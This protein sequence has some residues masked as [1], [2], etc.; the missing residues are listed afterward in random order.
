MLH[1][2]SAFCVRFQVYTCDAAT[3]EDCFRDM[4]ETTC[5]N[6]KAIS[7]HV[8]VLSTKEP[9]VSFQAQSLGDYFQDHIEVDYPKGH[10]A[11]LVF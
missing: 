4:K 9:T 7:F 10:D 1:Y 3:V 6:I 8:G 11:K 5:S 2:C